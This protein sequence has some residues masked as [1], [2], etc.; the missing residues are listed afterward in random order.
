[1]TAGC[2]LTVFLP[3]GVGPPLLSTAAEIGPLCRRVVL[4]GYT[5]E[6]RNCEGVIHRHVCENILYACIHIC[7]VYYVTI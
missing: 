5:E 7:H 6:A 2:K 3:L 4:L 1:M